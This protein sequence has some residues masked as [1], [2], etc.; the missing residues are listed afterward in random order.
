MWDYV[1]MQNND[2]MTHAGENGVY[3]DKSEITTTGVVCNV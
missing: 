2:Y 3:G 1:L